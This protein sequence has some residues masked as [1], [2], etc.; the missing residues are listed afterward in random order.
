MYGSEMKFEDFIKEYE[1]DNTEDKTVE[2]IDPITEEVIILS[3][4]E[5]KKYIKE[6]S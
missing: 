1:S 2:L 6:R 4:D 5:F 3:E